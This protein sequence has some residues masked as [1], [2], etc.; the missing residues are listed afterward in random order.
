MATFPLVVEATD[1]GG[2]PV[3][4]TPITFSLT[5]GQGSFGGQAVA[6]VATNS[7]GTAGAPFTFGA[8]A[9]AILVQAGFPGMLG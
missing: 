6:S 2:N 4:A 3:A 9:G 5:Q 7:S 1:A 8:A